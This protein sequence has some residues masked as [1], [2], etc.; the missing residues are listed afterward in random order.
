MGAAVTEPRALRV[1]QAKRAARAA[2]AGVLAVA[3]A[4]LS[5]RLV[6]NSSA[7]RSAPGF[8]CLGYALWWSYLLPVLVFGLTWPVLRLL[9][10]RPAW[11]TALL[12]TG[13]G[14]YLLW[15]L[16]S[17]RWLPNGTLLFQAAL[18]AGAFAFAAWCTQSRRPLW[19][20]AAA[21]LALAVLMPLDSFASTQLAHHKQNTEL[22]H[23][24]VPLLGPH[25]PD[26]YHLEG[27]GTSGTAHSS[28]PTF[29][30]RIAPNDAGRHAD[31]MEELNRVIQ[32]VVGPRLPNFTP[33]SHCTALTSV[34]PVPA[35]ACT[36]VAP[37]VWRWSRYDFVEYFA[38]VGDAVAV[39]EARTPPASSALLRDIAGSM[40]VRPPAYFTEH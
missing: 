31:S 3:A 36:P 21:A 17:L 27:V 22:A 2:V 24:G 15:C 32:V 12:G 11:L 37:G 1:R 29:Y 23:A 4:G 9:A 10:V 39:V 19:P 34:Y 40:R 25:I 16:D 6:V 30:Y 33:P 13:T 8:G 38:R 5:M 26:G 28:Q 7:C 35:P 18:C 14:W 20:R